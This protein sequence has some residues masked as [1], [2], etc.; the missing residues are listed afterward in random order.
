MGRHS[1]IQDFR[2][3]FL[4]G[5]AAVLPTVL[6]ISIIIWVCKFVYEY[7]ALYTNRAAQWLVVQI[8]GLFQEL[9]WTW[10]GND[11]LWITVN[12]IWTNYG[13]VWTGFVFAFILIYFFGKFVTSFIGKSLW[14]TVDRAFF[15]VPLI[16]QVYPSVKQVT[17][18]LLSDKK[19]DFSKVVAVQYPRI[20]VWSLGLVTADGMSMLQNPENDML[21]IFIP[22]SPM[23]VTGYTITVSRR[24]VVDL[25][26]S[27]DEALRFTV[28]GG[29]ITPNSKPLPDG[30]GSPSPK[31][32][33]NQ[34]ND[35]PQ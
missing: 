31:D 19:L 17:D 23:P 32:K 3:F 34:Q 26:F 15:S 25:P 12:G 8:M 10:A 28:S 30:T 11:D 24:D 13:L 18:F 6:T 27:I 35:S 7:I 21:T 1:F 22:S 5:L 29:V 20:G 2:R 4:R 33:A 14:R 9:E 16:K